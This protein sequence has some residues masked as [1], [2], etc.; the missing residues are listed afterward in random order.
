MPLDSASQLFWG[1]HESIPKSKVKLLWEETRTISLEVSWLASDWFSENIIR[2][3]HRIVATHTFLG[4][5]RVF[6]V[7]LQI[8]ASP[9]RKSPSKCPGVF[10][11]V[12]YHELDLKKRARSD[13][14]LFVRLL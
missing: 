4:Q 14:A 9:S 8:S 6:S 11:R 12:P 13:Q 2:I 10:L 1:L 7:W 3:A 5:C